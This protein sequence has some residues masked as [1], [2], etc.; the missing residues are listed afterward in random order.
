MPKKVL[1]N[2]DGHKIVA[3]FKNEEEY[4]WYCRAMARECL[5]TLLKS[6][7]LDEL[8]SLW[9]EKNPSANT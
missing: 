5:D 3:D 2:A 9:H 1:A 7:S 6:L 4:S 8:T